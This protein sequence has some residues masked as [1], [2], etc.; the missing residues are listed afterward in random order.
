MGSFT[1]TAV[2]RRRRCDG[3]RDERREER[4]TSKASAAAADEALVARDGPWGVHV[5]T[6]DVASA[7]PCAGRAPP[8]YA[9]RVGMADV[10]FSCAT[11]AGAGRGWTLTLV[12]HVARGK[13]AL[14]AELTSDATV[15]HAQEQGGEARGRGAVR[16]KDYRFPFEEPRA[17]NPCV[18]VL[19]NGL[20]ANRVIEKSSLKNSTG[21]A[22]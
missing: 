5:K 19:V 4:R 3:D 22:I 18:T 7:Q 17:N 10:V 2:G 9:F 11:T 20:R 8:G 14:R 21:C 15:A 6:S 1:A 16:K 13:E 12:R